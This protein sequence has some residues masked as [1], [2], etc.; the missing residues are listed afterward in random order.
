MK[1]HCLLIKWDYKYDKESTWFDE[2]S[3]E[4]RYE[5]VPSTHDLPKMMRK[6]FDIL[7]V[8][9][10]EGKITAELIIDGVP[11]TLSEGDE[12]YKKHVSYDYSVCGDCVS[13]DLYMNI[14]I[15]L[16]E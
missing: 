6:R 7:R 16:D 14:S 5:L 4:D 10:T 8:E 1:K 11:V 12:P 3:G 13:T 2:D 15:A 9:E